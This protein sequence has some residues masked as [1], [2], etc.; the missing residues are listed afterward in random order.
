MEKGGS[1]LRWGL[2]KSYSGKKKVRNER[3]RR[4][5]EK[6]HLTQKGCGGKGCKSVGKGKVPEN[7]KKKKK[8]MTVAGGGLEKGATEH[9]EIKTEN[10]G[11][12]WGKK[13]EPHW[14]RKATYDWARQK[15]RTDC[16]GKNRAK[17]R[18]PNKGKGRT[19]WRKLPRR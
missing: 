5:K 1:T 16:R 10:S 12:P 15:K 4:A 14:L 13:R 8:E 17:N 6:S 3:G 19:Y 11:D 18:S 9:L 2:D 7:R